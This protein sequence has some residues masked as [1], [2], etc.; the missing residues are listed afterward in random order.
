MKLKTQNAQ[1][2]S[3]LKQKPETA[4]EQEEKPKKRERRKAP[5]FT[6]VWSEEVRSL[7]DFSANEV[8]ELR[9]KALWRIGLA[10]AALD[11]DPSIAQLGAAARIDDEIWS[12]F[13]VGRYEFLIE[14]RP[15]KIR[16]YWVMLAPEGPPGEE[17]GGPGAL[18]C[19]A[20]VRRANRL[21][22]RTAGRALRACRTLTDWIG[23]RLATS[24][25]RFAQAVQSCRHEICLRASDLGESVRN[26]SSALASCADWFNRWRHLS[27][28]YEGSPPDACLEPRCV[29]Q[30]S[31]F[32]VL[33]YSWI[34]HEPPPVDW[35]ADL[36]GVDW[37]ANL[38]GVLSEEE[39][40]LT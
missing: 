16:E 8:I 20:L 18:A 26:L 21:A 27:V 1:Q 38:F 40:A 2:P 37:A 39:R 10:E 32:H 19:D 9:R 13:A 35:G 5:R 34:G 3:T 11:S 24:S 4:K 6:L 29:G 15:A 23:A 7:P 36:F 25:Q 22:R 31:G 17:G 33:L 14:F 28:Q 30:N 12:N